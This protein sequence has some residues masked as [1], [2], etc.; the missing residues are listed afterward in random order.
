MAIYHLH[1]GFVSRSS[2][3]SAVQAAAYIS[4]E[5]LHEDRRNQTIYYHKQQNEVALVKTLSPENSRYKDIAVWNVIENFED[6]YAENHFKSAETQE[7]YKMSVQ[8]ASTIVLALPNELSIK[9]N[10]ELLDKFINTRFTDRGL[11]TTYAIHQKDGNLHAHLLISRRAVGENGDF[12]LR[13]DREICTKFNLCETRK[14]WANLANE[15]LEREGV[16]DRITE[17]SFEDLGIN[18]E[19]TKH[20]GWYSDYIGTDSR[21]AQE[22]L[23]IAK[24]NEER[25]LSNPSII[26]DYLNEKKAVFTQKDILKVISERIADDRNISAVFERVLDEAKYVGESINGEFLYTGEKY[27]KLE[28]D[29][30][31]RFDRLFSLKA[32]TH[33]ETGTVSEVLDKF[34]YFSEEQK[35]A[36]RGL[37]EDDNFG[38]LIGKAGAG[39]TATIRAI[40][41]IYKRSGARVIGMSLSAV[42]S[43][44]LGKDADI[45]S[46]TIASWEY[47]W[48]IYEK[49]K[50]KFL[51]SIL[52][53]GLLKQL[54]WFKDMKRYEGDQLK[55]GDVIVVDEAGMVG[56]KEWKT[57]LEKAEKFGAKIVAV[58]DDNQ[59]NPISS[60]DC[61][62]KFKT[63]AFE[64]KEI[65]RQKEGWQK[66]A[67]AEFSKLNIGT[68]L[69][70][71]ERHESIHVLSGADTVAYRYCENEKQG[72]T[73]VL[74]FTKKECAIINNLVREIKKNNAELGEDIF[75]IGDRG[76]AKND[77]IVFT[78][79]NKQFDI[80]NGQTGVV[81]AFKDGVLCVLTENG[82]K[83][84]KIEEYNKIDYA[85]AITL[86]KSQ[87]KTYDRTVVLASKFMDAKATYVAMTRHRE[88]VDLYYRKSDFKTFG[89]LVRSA[90]KYAYKD[91]LEDYKNIDN[92]NKARVI[93][94]KEL[95]IEKAQ[96]LRDIHSGTENWA[97]YN[98]LKL[99]SLDLGREMLRDFDSHKLYLHQQGITREKLE[100]QC[101]L[102]QR[103]LSNIEINAKNT[104]ELYAKISQTAR[105]I[106]RSMD[107]F[108]IIQNRRYM[109]YCKIRDARNNLARTILADYPL[110][111]EFV[112]QASRA[113]FISRKDMQSQ[114]EYANKR[115]EIFLNQLDKLE[116]PLGDNQRGKYIQNSLDFIKEEIKSPSYKLSLEINNS[117][118]TPYVNQSM[119]KNY[120]LDKGLQVSFQEHM[121]EYANRLIQDRIERGQTITPNE[122]ISSIKQAVC[123][124]SLRQVSD[125][126]IEKLHEQAQILSNRLVDKNIRV[127]NDKNLMM[128]ANQ[129]ISVK[130]QTDIPLLRDLIHDCGRSQSAEVSI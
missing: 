129:D 88:R 32:K 5:K 120:L 90:S 30:L 21:I 14:L 51:S 24:Q 94:Y 79:N 97:E 92:Q 49:A 15:F 106:F 36:V 85:Y 13:K 46:A 117:G 96:A 110:Y 60:G 16:K 71:Y 1:S 72:T 10:E 19:A 4:G 98:K 12:L 102:R 108:N 45:E 29:V 6:K 40:A 52:N 27:Q 81:Q 11:I 62:S 123:L 39:K 107:T 67:S 53:D 25:I 128:Q 126:P 28:S 58:G 78:E 115:C 109:E 124:E 35:T 33:C 103:P 91:S 18:L 83:S 42:A 31:T 56:T 2:G 75:K 82:A 61:F 22:N 74:C 73:V 113:F 64:L 84:I 8:T 9:T 66:L 47:R 116:I 93:E 44:N 54:D 63:K 76:F 43:E 80:K 50:E 87:G 57:I 95:Q 37:T 125:A 101:G 48:R 23:K 105:A 89:A 130:V 111:R 100:I 68:A 69:E 65:R 20:R 118:L 55:S 86:H 77:R 127:L 104:V 119:L 38:V 112:S 41:D 34:S 99:R 122:I 3:R 114:V 70:M 7:N 26:L 121:C 59:F 17:K